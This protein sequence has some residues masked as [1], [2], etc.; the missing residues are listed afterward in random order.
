MARPDA[1]DETSPILGGPLAYAHF[2]IESNPW[3]SAHHI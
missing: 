3:Y 1:G 2:V